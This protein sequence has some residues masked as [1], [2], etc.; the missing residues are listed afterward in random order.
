MRASVAKEKLESKSQQQ[1]IEGGAQS[2][3]V[4]LLLRAVEAIQKYHRGSE[5]GRA[6]VEGTFLF[7]MLFI[8]PIPITFFED[9]SYIRALYFG[10][11]VMTTVGYGDVVP[12][13]SAGI[14]YTIF[15]IPFNVAFV[16]IL[17]G[18]VARYYLFAGNHYIQKMY[19]AAVAEKKKNRMK[20]GATTT[21]AVDEE[22]FAAITASDVLS[23]V[24][25]EFDLPHDLKE[26][27]QAEAEEEEQDVEENG[28][29]VARVR[30][31]QPGHREALSLATFSLA[32]SRLVLLVGYHMAGTSF[33]FS[34]RGKDSYV[35]IP[36]LDEAVSSWF[37]PSATRPLLALVSYELLLLVGQ[38]KLAI[39]GPQVI[40]QIPAEKLYRILAPAIAA[41][42]NTDT[43]HAWL[44]WTVKLEHETEHDMVMWSRTVRQAEEPVHIADGVGDLIDL[45]RLSDRF[46]SITDKVELNVVWNDAKYK[47]VRK[48]SILILLLLLAYEIPITI[49]VIF[50]ADTNVPEG[51]VFTGYTLTSAGFGSV[52]IP[53][54][55]GFLA[56]AVVNVF[57]SIILLFAAVSYGVRNNSAPMGHA[58]LRYDCFSLLP[59]R[60]S[61]CLSLDSNR[62]V[63]AAQGCR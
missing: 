45:D 40:L 44:A 6:V 26:N 23:L 25:A 42:G 17:M 37:I 1:E 11:F 27:P 39:D 20:R 9:W 52:E 46:S 60:T 33:D 48:A 7:T 51:L 36:K 16:C 2:H 43:I 29:G 24:Q 19:G 49:L 5:T 13:S 34:L 57:I 62:D 58:L 56:F 54:D 47:S 35:K 18:N 8:A 50:I 55:N 41:F 21:N 22:I 38:R 32:S 31:L 28:L 53:K 3:H 61:S 12:T 4:N 15:W 14:W 10:T 30:V 59:G 63:Q